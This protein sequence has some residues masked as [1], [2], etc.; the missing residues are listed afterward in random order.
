LIKRKVGPEQGQHHNN[1]DGFNSATQELVRVWNESTEVLLMTLLLALLSFWLVRA[2]GW[3]PVSIT[4]GRSTARAF[5]MFDQPIH[6]AFGERRAGSFGTLDG[7]A[8]YIVGETNVRRDRGKWIVD[9]KSAIIRL[10]T[11]AACDEKI[12]EWGERFH[13]ICG[14]APFHTSFL[15]SLRLATHQYIHYMHAVYAQVFITP[16]TSK[17]ANRSCRSRST[18]TRAGKFRMKIVDVL[19]VQVVA[20]S[21]SSRNSSISRRCLRR[22]QSQ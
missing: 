22:R 14:W 2:A 20:V 5:L 9:A 4:K 12:C 16:D 15:L 21:F 3:H 10:E 11:F 18:P 17:F 13:R 7:L 1:D 6:D 19:L 8:V